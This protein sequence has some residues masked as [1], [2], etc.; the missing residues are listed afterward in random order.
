M[1]VS[2]KHNDLENVGP[3]L[4]HHTFF[5]MLGNF[6][7]G[8]YFKDDAIALAWALLTDVWKLPA[9]R[10]FATVFA[11]RRR[12]AARRRGLRVLAARAAGGPD[13]R[14]GRGGQLLVDGRDRAR[15]AAA[16][17]FTTTAATTCPAR[18]RC[19]AA[20]S[21]PA[22]A[23]SRS[24][25]TSSWS[26]TARPTARSCRCR[27]RRSTRAW[28]SSASRRSCRARCRTTTRTCSSR[29]STAIGQLAGRPYGGTME[30]ADVSMRVIAD[31]ARAMT[32]LIAD[33]VVPSN[34][35]RGYVLRKIMR[36]AMRHG[37][38][39]GLTEPFLC[40][41]VDVLVGPD[42][43]RVPGAE[44]RPRLRVEG[45]RQRRG[46]LRGRADHRAAAPRGPARPVGRGR[47]RAGR[48]RR[49]GCT[50][51][52]A[53]RWT[54][55]RTPRRSAASTIDREGFERALE[56]QRERAR[57]EE[58]VRRRPS[59]AEFFAP[60]DATR[61][62]LEQAGDQF[63]GYTTTRVTGVPV[64]ALFD[65]SG[66]EVAGARRRGGRASSRSPGRRSTSSR[67]ARCRTPGASSRNRAAFTAASTG[68]VEGGRAGRGC[69]GSRSSRARCRRATS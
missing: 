68:V 58:R 3:S 61:R 4:R 66:K 25:T 11:R 15:A 23:T 65:A 52:T 18:S 7:F 9:D 6:S 29:C 31:H 32:F 5:E 12:R 38:R 1:R 49:S 39:L 47:R 30:P 8:D 19:A 53:C 59:Q 44:V 20:W 14:T 41:L 45:R 34:E 28:A 67:A 2:G 33:G 22:T 60:S 69:T 26:S 46:A 57:A 54:S 40:T 37:N 27:R 51:R 36:R 10:L 35:W 62:A 56:A 24:G 43:R 16:R 50:T 21:A 13:R 48:R 42:G 55:S 64:L 63:E 17:R